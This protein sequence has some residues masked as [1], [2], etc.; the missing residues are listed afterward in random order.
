MNTILKILGDAFLQTFL[1]VA[2][3]GCV[4]SL[5]IG[6]W[7]LIK[8]EGVLRLNQNLSRWFGTEKLAAALDTPHRIDNALYR[9]HRWVGVLVLVGGLYIFYVMLFAFNKKVA[10]GTLNYGLNPQ[11]AWLV[12]ALEMVLIVSSVLALII[13]FFLVARPS[14]FKRFEQWGNRWYSTDKS[15][16]VLEAMNLK[17]DEV[18]MRHHRI[19]AALIIAASVFVIVSFL[20]VLL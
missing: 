20:V 13:G 11:F 6:V 9:K 16:R 17:S 19:V 3:A 12:D 7:V 5:I 15:L 2:A 8:P 10:V 14:A 1:I 18:M 4:L